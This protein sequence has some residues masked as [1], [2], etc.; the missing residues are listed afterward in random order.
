MEIVCIFEYFC[1]CLDVIVL[2]AD[3]NIIERGRENVVTNKSTKV[4][5][6][7]VIKGA[8]KDEI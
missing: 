6:K 1:I 4:F 3:I 8:I 2:T 7:D 5:R